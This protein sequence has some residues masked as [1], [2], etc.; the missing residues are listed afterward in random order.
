LNFIPLQ[1]SLHKFGYK[2]G[3]RNILVFGFLKEV[4][5]KIIG[6]SEI[7]FKI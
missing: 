7:F 3:R 1:A 5:P 2:E 4:L 6:S